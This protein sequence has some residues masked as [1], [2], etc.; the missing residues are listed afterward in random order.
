[1]GGDDIDANFVEAEGVEDAGDGDGFVGGG[2]DEGTGVVGA[3]GAVGFVGFAESIVE[4][5]GAL[6]GGHP[7]SVDGAE[8]EAVGDG[9]FVGGCGEGEEDGDG[10]GGSGEPSTGGFACDGGDVGGASGGPMWLGGE[11][12]NEGTVLGVDADDGA[13]TEARDEGDVG[14]RG[15]VGAV[16]DGEFVAVVGGDVGGKR[17]GKVGAD[18]L[19]LLSEE[20]AVHGRVLKGCAE[21]GGCG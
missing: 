17:A 9:G 10:A 20:G 18:G 8:R 7:V 5:A 21:H 19:G 12:V 3:L 14:P 4:A 11:Q 16:E 6:F 2:I 13:G 1:M 15:W